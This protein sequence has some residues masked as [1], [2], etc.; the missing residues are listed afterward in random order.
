MSAIRPFGARLFV[1]LVTMGLAG[2]ILTGCAATPA[3][4]DSA[5]ASELQNGVLAVS[6]AAAAGDFATAQTA[7]DAVRGSL[8]AASAEDAVTA[9]KAA[10]IQSAIDLVQAD[11]AASIAASIPAEIPSETATPEPV[12]TEGD[13]KEEPAKPDKPGKD[14]SDTGACKKKDKCD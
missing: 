6:T 11:L 10:S 14:K 13:P 9:A 8:G 12:N 5:T 4:I 2:G 3:S 1:G 7:L